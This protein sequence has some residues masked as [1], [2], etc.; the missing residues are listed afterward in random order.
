MGQGAVKAC[1]STRSGRL[2]SKLT[3]IMQ[4]G[5]R[6]VRSLMN[7]SDG[8]DTSTS[9]SEVMWNTPS[10]YVAP[11][12]FLRLRRSRKP[13]ADS[14]SKCSTVSTRCSRTFGPAKKPS[15]VTWPTR[16]SAKPLVFASRTSVWAQHRTWLMEPGAEVNSVD[17]STWIESMT[18]T[19][20]AVLRMA[21]ITASTWV[22]ASKAMAE[23]AKPSRTARSFVCRKLSSPL[24]YKTRTRAALRR[25]AMDSRR[26]DLP[27]PGSPPTSVTD[28]GTI[29]PP[30]TRSSS[31]IPVGMRAVSSSATS[32]SGVGV[33]DSSVR[34]PALRGASSTTSSTSAFQAPQEGQRPAHLMA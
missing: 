4:P 30:S 34:M 9:P 29:P 16:N 26:V 28:P 21:S 31:P 7:N 11:K 10:S 3:V 27:M 2:P 12:R 32:A 18:T 14:P 24:T 6:S 13:L 15:F 8:L 1:S 22:W 33:T 5:A 17:S 23:E 25:P 20:G 19:C